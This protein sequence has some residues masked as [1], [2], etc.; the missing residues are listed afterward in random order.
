MAAGFESASR[1]TS[2]TSAVARFGASSCIQALKR[3]MTCAF[4]PRSFGNCLNRAASMLANDVFPAPHGAL[5]DMVNGVSTTS[6]RMMAS[7]CA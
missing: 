3:Q 5:M 6:S 7:D 4:R 2:A 1:L